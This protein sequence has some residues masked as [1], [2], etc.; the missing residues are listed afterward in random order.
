MPPDE[1]NRRQQAGAL[2]GIGVASFARSASTMTRCSALRPSNSDS[3][4]LPSLSIRSSTHAFASA[5]SATAARIGPLREA[6]QLA[7]ALAAA[8]RFDDGLAAALDVEP[9][10][11]GRAVVVELRVELATVADLREISRD[12]L[13][14]GLGHHAAERHGV[15]VHGRSCRVMSWL[16]PPA[17]NG[18]WFVAE[19]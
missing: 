2:D 11:R 6:V 12:S 8:G 5:P 16:P 13:T 4:W 14:A 18:I 15:G 1:R 9:D 10:H 17:V 7:T 3:W 19:P